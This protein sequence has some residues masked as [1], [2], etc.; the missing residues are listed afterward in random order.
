[1]S[2]T[3]LTK[4]DGQIL[5]GAEINKCLSADATGNMGFPDTGTVSLPGLYP[6]GD[7]NTG[8][9]SPG[10]DILALATGG[11]ER[12]RWSSTGTAIT[13][14]LSC[15]ALTSTGIDLEVSSASASPKMILQNT[16]T[17]DITLQLLLT[18]TQGWAL[19]IDNDDGDKFKIC[20]SIGGNVADDTR[21][22][23]DTSGNVGIGTT[24]PQQ[25]IDIKGAIG[26]TG[27]TSG[28]RKVFSIK[29]TS[30]EVFHHI[31]NTTG[32]AI[33][34]RLDDDS[35]NLGALT[36]DG[37]LGIGS[38]APDVKLILQNSD[39]SD[40][41]LLKLI[42][43]SSNGSANHTA[44]EFWG[45]EGAGAVGTL[46]AQGRIYGE[47][48]SSDAT[49]AHLVLGSKNNSGGYHDEVTIRQGNVGINETSP[50]THKLHVG[51]DLKIGKSTGNGV[52]ELMFDNSKFTLGNGST[53]TVD[54]DK[55][56][57]L[58]ITYST[59]GTEFFGGLFHAEYYS[60]TV[61]EISDPSSKFEVT[62]TGTLFSVYKSA[63]SGTV[64]IKNRTGN[65]W[66]VS[67]QVFKFQGI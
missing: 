31:P 8:M 14:A 21:L 42:N 39:T 23:I 48:D 37:N 33:L 10:A 47:Y 20:S 25:T 29:S 3:N 65:S 60:A 18:G 35:A 19:G 57:L 51:G 58:S 9:W 54:V 36:K 63:S 4:S 34:W 43:N 22:T 5:S 7:T 28:N 6:N 44:L 2:H 16:S 27:S 38:T 66:Y 17:G 15:G 67:I 11:S 26:L 32:G 45:D 53:V 12:I 64:T 24:S 41:T 55:A 46:L 49:S 59:G 56:V 52:S 40:S 50:S 61:T 1:M 30:T 13:G 62:D